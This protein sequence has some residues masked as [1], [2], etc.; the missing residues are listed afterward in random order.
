MCCRTW[1]GHNDV[2]AKGCPGFD[3]AAW[4]EEQE[5]I[6]AERH[7]GEPA[8]ETIW[9]AIASAVAKLLKGGKA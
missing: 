2:A 6:D 9:E 3:V 7:E 4:R 5:A 8:P 1:I